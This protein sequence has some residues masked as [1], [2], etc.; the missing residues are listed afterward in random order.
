MGLC[1]SGIA[2]TTF[3]NISDGRRLEDSFRPERRKFGNFSSK[4]WL[5]GWPHRCNCPSWLASWTT[6]WWSR[7]LAPPRGLESRF[8]IH[9]KMRRI[10]VIN[11][12]LKRYW[13]CKFEVLLETCG[14]FCIKTLRKFSVNE[15]SQSTD[16]SC[17]SGLSK[18]DP[19]NEPMPKSNFWEVGSPGIEPHPYSLFGSAVGNIA[20]CCWNKKVGLA[21]GE[22]ESNL[23]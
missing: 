12:I 18:A 5:N 14:L 9:S 10:G 7:G 17:E 22:M 11:Y 1:G 23:H 20:D 13:N 4:Q 15:A 19:H 2:S 16:E 6:L 21:V 3:V 8:S